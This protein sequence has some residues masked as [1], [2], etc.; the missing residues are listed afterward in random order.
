MSQSANGS[1][2]PWWAK[3]L[4]YIGV[5]SFLLLYVMGAFPFLPSPLLGQ[6]ETKAMIQAHDQRTRRTSE[7][8]RLTCAGVWRG[9]PERQKDCDR[10]AESIDKP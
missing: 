5:P 8:W 2:G 10:A 9:D 3:L 6:A 4:G 7:L 1:N